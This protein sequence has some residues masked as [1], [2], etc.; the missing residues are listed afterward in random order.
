MDDNDD[1]TFR[2]DHLIRAGN[3]DK[4][5]HRPPGCDDIQDTTEQ[6]IVPVAV[7]GTW[8]FSKR[9]PSFV[10]DNSKDIEETFNQITM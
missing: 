7:S 8:D 5:W 1:G 4:I 3:G 9:K 6:Q 2:G 10:I